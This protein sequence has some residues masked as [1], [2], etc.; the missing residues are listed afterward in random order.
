MSKKIIIKGHRLSDETATICI[1][2]MSSKYEDIFSEVS[3]SIEA[4]AQMIELRCDMFDCIK[5]RTVLLKLL[6]DIAGIAKN[7][8][9]LFTIRTDVEGGNITISDE[10]YSDILISVA[11]SGCVDLIDVE[12]TH[13]CDATGLI[14]RLHQKN[15]VVVASH[16]NFNETYENDRILEI[17]ARLDASGAD[18]LKLAMMPQ[19]REDVLRLMMCTEEAGR[20]Y[21]SKLFISIAMGSIGQVSRVASGLCGSAVT[22]ASLKC[23][24]APGQLSFDDTRMVLQIL[25]QYE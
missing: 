24:S 22:F 21:E 7:T 19:S 5:E 23:D 1:P 9:L 17:Y 12:A 6:S 11:D 25:N 10:E 20:L 15:V 2:I 13:I 8:I 16:H 18:I 4:G 3:E 14:Y